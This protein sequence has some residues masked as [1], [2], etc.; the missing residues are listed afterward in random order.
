MTLQ[1]RRL[2][3]FA[4]LLALAAGALPLHAADAKGDPKRTVN[5]NNAD[6]AQ[7]ALLPRV[8]ASVAERIVEYRKKNGP[9][10]TAEDLML[11]RGIGEKTF[12][13]LRPYV[14]VAGETTLKEKVHSSRSGTTKTGGAKPE[15]KAS[16]AKAGADPEG[17]R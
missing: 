13:L 1:P 17:S 5:V 10:K 9:F 14:A 8:G 11:V 7:L 12:Q 16:G 2:F 6:V 15:G 4:V 3:A